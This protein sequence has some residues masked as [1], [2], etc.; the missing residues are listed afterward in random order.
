MRVYR[1]PLLF[2]PVLAAVLPATSELGYAQQRPGVRT[3]VNPPE[4]CYI[5]DPPDTESAYS[6][7]KTQ[8]QAL[9]FAGAGEKANRTALMAEGGVPLEQMG[10][11][12]T[13]LRQERTDNMCAGFVVAAYKQSNNAN[14]AAAAE[15]LSSDYDELGRM[16]DQMLKLAL[17]EPV[18]R[19]MGHSTDGAFA[20]L[21]R[22]RQE[23]LGRM[24]EVLNISL[25]LLVD[26]SHSDASGKLDRLILSEAERDALLKYLH[27]RFPALKSPKGALSGDFVKQAALINS[28]LSGTYKPA[29][30]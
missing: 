25:L 4:S 30:Q 3:F 5:S 24:T 17:E 7:M 20:E 10:E 18:Q 19:K 26:G 16:A 27:S 29:N 23:T 8:I 22:K 14:I 9:S 11:V 6:F 1:F 28:F 15:L 21:K 13:G 12:L 2:F